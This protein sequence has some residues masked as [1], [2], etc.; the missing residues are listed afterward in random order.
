MK[1]AV[2]EE[3]GKP[4]VLKELP[5]P[6]PGPGKLLLKVE[7][8]GVCGSDIHASMGA[9]APGTIMGHEY[10]GRVVEVGEGVAGTWQPGD[11]LIAIGAKVCGKC[12]AC[13]RGEQLACETL[14]MQG[15]DPEEQGAYAEYTTCRADM[16]FKLPADFDPRQAA[17]IEPLS[18]GLQ[19]WRVAQV[20]PGSD[21]LVIGAGAI[22]LAVVKWAR[23]FGARSVTVSEMV[24]ARLRRAE[25]AGATLTVDAAKVANPVA[26]FKA[27]TGRE[28]SVIFE[29]IG[30]PIFAPLVEM[31]PKGVHIVMVGACMESES[32]QS[33]MACVKRLRVTY[34][35]AYEREDFEFTLEML[36]SGL[37]T[38]DPLITA[39]V[40]M[41]AFPAMFES[42]KQPNDHCKVLV[43]P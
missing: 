24:P 33:V 40:G 17:A 27:Q 1:A 42:L 26:A 7:A 18:V 16:A 8:C 14:V 37:L 36:V 41:D 35:F 5:T 30:R 10:A 28:P 22:G 6:R 38:V 2:Y 11:K 13:L 32:F 39:T 43:T 12:P 9:V 29:C 20:A 19:A 15:F 25:L 34:A 21:V 3:A 23:F 31:A 4:L